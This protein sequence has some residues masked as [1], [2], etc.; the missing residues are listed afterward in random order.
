MTLKRYALA[1]AV[2]IGAGQFVLPAPAGARSRVWHVV[3]MSLQA[4]KGIPASRLSP[5]PLTPVRRTRGFRYA[6]APSPLL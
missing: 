2:L 5:A 3:I 1:V 4:R 6:P